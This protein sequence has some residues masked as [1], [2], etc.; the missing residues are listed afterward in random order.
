M[1]LWSSAMR[2]IAYSML[3]LVSTVCLSA[4][5]ALKSLGQVG[6]YFDSD[7]DPKTPRDFITLADVSKLATG[8]SK[9]QVK[10]RLGP[11][12]NANKDDEDRFDYV[13][14]SVK[15]GKAEL[16]PY[17]VKFVDGKVS[18]FG[19]VADQ[20]ILPPQIPFEPREP[21][22]VAQE[23]PSSIPVRPVTAAEIGLQAL[24]IKDEIASVVI[25]WAM[26]WSTKDF[27]TYVAFYARSFKPEKGNIRSW[28]ISRKARLSGKDEIDVSVS[29]FKVRELPSNKLEVVF[30]QKYTSKKVNERGNKTLLF[31][32]QDSDWKIER[33]TFKPAK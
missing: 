25:A 18:K 10:N 7:F 22:P 15:A 9:V 21:A 23:A 1:F 24:P 12:L 26:A 20:T 29:D 3:V 5:S 4:C 31:V 30:W 16:V 17:Y 28:A 2:P 33:E 13:F 11:P 27:P 8:M 14:R 32:K 19:M 6:E